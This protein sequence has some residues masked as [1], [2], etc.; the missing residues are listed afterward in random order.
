MPMMRAASST[1][2][3]PALINEART[4]NKCGGHI[5]EKLTAHPQLGRIGCAI[6]RINKPTRNKQTAARGERVVK[7]VSLAKKQDYR[8][9]NP[10]CWVDFDAGPKI[11]PG[12]PGAR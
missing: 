4:G 8:S 12:P 10:R 5:A 9:D 6:Q 2:R 7:R 1:K 3:M 11:R